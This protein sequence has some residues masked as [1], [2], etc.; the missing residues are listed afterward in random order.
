LILQW[1]ATCTG[2]QISGT[3][4]NNPSTAVAQSGPR[5][6]NTRKPLLN[7]GNSRA[8]IGDCTGSARGVGR[9]KARCRGRSS[10][11][12]RGSLDGRQSWMSCARLPSLT[13]ESCEVA[14]ASNG[15]S[16]GRGAT[17]EKGRS[18]GRPGPAIPADLQVIQ[19]GPGQFRADKEP[20]IAGTTRD[21]R[22]R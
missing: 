9:A 18:F 21:E 8:G 6:S 4:P 5:M 22:V 16:S 19:G 7:V 17:S 20:R 10:R 2:Y 12:S 13:S 11:R 1:L 3:L 15:S 14:T